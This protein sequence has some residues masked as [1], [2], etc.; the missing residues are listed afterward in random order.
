[1]K[2]KCINTLVA[3]LTIMTVT[4]SSALP[5]FAEPTDSQDGLSAV[6]E[7]NNNLN[8]EKIVENIQSCDSKI[9][10]KMTKLNELKEQIAQKEEEIKENQESISRAEDK[11]EEKDKALSDRVK[12]IQVSGGLETTTLKYLDALL[13]SGNV[14]EAI[15]KVK[16]LE[17]QFNYDKIVDEFAKT[18]VHFWRRR[19]HELFPDRN[20]IDNIGNE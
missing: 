1:M 16:R 10:Y 15:E 13:T 4:T 5:A 11:I 12:Q 6:S 18:L 19:A 2:R 8:I 20:T 3:V 17:K 7:S 14:L 9:E